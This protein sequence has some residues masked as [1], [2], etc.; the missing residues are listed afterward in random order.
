MSHFDNL[1]SFRQK[2][3]LLLKA[4]NL[5]SYVFCSVTEDY[6]QGMCCTGGTGA[7]LSHLLHQLE[8]EIKKKSLN[9]NV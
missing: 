5:G 4:H 2:L 8:I 6:E 7:D 3:R 1:E 9:L